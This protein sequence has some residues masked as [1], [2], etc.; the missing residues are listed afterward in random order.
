MPPAAAARTTNNQQ[1]QH[2][3]HPPIAWLPASWTLALL[4]AALAVSAFVSRY[5]P[6]SYMV[7]SLQAGLALLCLQQLS[8]THTQ[9]TPLST[10]HLQPPPTTLFWRQTQQHQDEPF[11]VPMA[12]QYCAGDLVSWDPK[13]TT[14]PGLYYLGAGYAWLSHLLL[15]P[16]VGAKLVGC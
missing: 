14:F 9:H 2:H 13:I 4:T 3:K 8:V 1:Q 7:N 5:A 11:H 15:Y 6:D 10:D 16:F 12:Q